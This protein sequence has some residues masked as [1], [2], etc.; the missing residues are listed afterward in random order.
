MN[1]ATHFFLKCF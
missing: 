1:V